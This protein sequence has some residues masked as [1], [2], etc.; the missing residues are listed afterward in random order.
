MERH[1]K[2]FPAFTNN[3]DTLYAR[4]PPKRNKW[5]AS[6]CYYKRKADTSVNKH[7][8]CECKSQNT[9]NIHNTF[10]Y[11]KWWFIEIL[12]ASF[13]HNFHGIVSAQCILFVAHRQYL[14]I[15]NE[16]LLIA[17]RTLL[18]IGKQFRFMMALEMR[19]LEYNSKIL[20]FIEYRYR[21]LHRSCCHQSWYIRCLKTV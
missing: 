8:E 3:V 4:A 21:Y 14:E 12:I 16:Q 7:S 19:I 6:A 20:V 13:L 2:I 10:I 15:L 18:T 17:K 11:L 9:Y 5:N 1:S